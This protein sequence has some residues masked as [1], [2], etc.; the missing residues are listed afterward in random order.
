MKPF[1]QLNKWGTQWESNLLVKVCWF[2]LLTIT[3]PEVPIYM[4]TEKYNKFEVKISSHQEKQNY[5]QTHIPV[6]ISLQL[7]KTHQ[8]GL[9]ITYFWW[10]YPK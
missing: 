6:N 5:K 4:F 8:F 3:P 9:D 2:S 1:A 10:F 7:G